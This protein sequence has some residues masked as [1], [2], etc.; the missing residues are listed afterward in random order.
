MNLKPPALLMPPMKWTHFLSVLSALA[1]VLTGHGQQVAIHNGIIYCTTNGDGTINISDFDYTGPNGDVTLPG[2]IDGLPVTTIGNRA[3]AFQGNLTSIIIPATVTSLGEEAFQS[4]DGLNAIYFEGEPPIADA[5]VFDNAYGATAFYTPNSSGWD[6]FAINSGLDVE[7]EY[8]YTTNDN[9]ITITN[10][11]GPGG[12]VSIPSIITGLPV[13]AIGD[14]A[15]YGA[16]ASSVIIPSGVTT[17]GESAFSSCSAMMD[18]AIPVTVTN[19][20]GSALSY[21]SSLTNMTIPFGVSDI[22][23]NEFYECTSLSNLTIPNTV[24]NIAA[25]AFYGCTSLINIVIPNGVVNIGPSAFYNCNDLDSVTIA[26]SVTNIGDSAFAECYNLISVNI[27]KGITIIEPGTFA[28]CLYLPSIS[29][30]SNVVAIGAAAFNNCETLSNV[31]MAN[32]LE[33]IG[34]NAFTTCYGLRNI[35]IPPSVTNIGA[36]A[37]QACPLMAV[38]FQ[39]NA[40][41]ADPNAFA[42]DSSVYF[43][44]PGA[45]AYYLEGSIGWGTNLGG[46]PT[47]LWMPSLA[48]G[49]RSANGA[50]TILHYIGNGGSVTVPTEIEGLPVTAVA[51]Y[52]LSQANVTSVSI[53]NGVTSIGTGAFSGCGYLTNITLPDGVL[54]IADNE[55]SGCTNLASIVIPSSVTNI[56]TNAF[57]GSGLTNITI[58]ENVV[59][60]GNAA[61]SGCIRLNGVTLDGVSNIGANAFAGTGLRSVAIPSTLLSIGLN[62]FSNCIDLTSITVNAADPSYAALTGCCLI[63]VKPNLSQCRPV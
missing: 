38:Y 51:E 29:I 42:Q 58:P 31:V 32:G 63:K 14:D 48:F 11:V 30:P 3:F 47:A 2:E 59:N 40:P 36:Y 19:I 6:N 17:I 55:F 12:I 4:C 15:F 23:T 24:T 28:D 26:D 16:F 39:G 61:F 56:G 52:A 33:S 37:F 8:G 45:T 35:L 54:A 27:P 50:M 21:C 60:I 20:G 46:L 13:T 1:L 18:I 10:Y 49:F 62:A 34:D 41:F 22:D 25:E 7:N 9:N 5:T 53:P 44:G 57:G 43:G